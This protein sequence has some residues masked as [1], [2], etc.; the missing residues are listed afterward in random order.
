ML[1]QKLTHEIF[2]TK[3]TFFV[4]QS[5]GYWFIENLGIILNPE[6]FDYFTVQEVPEGVIPGK[7]CYTE[8]KGFYENPNWIEPEE[9]IEPAMYTLDEAAAIIAS[10]VANNE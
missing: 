9:P 3:E 7:Y 1:T 6:Q 2:T 4:I 5:T 8:E 10:E